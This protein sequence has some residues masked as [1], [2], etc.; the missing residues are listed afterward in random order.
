VP[1]GERRAQILAKAAPLE[2]MRG[3]DD[4]RG[5]IDEFLA[6][7]GAGA[8]DVPSLLLRTRFAWLVVLLDPKTAEPMRMLLGKKIE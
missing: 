6:E 8:K 2:R 4:V 7:A 5:A 1:Y 3:D